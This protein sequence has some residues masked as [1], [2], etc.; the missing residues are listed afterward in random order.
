MYQSQGGINA[1]MYAVVQ[2]SYVMYRCIRYISIYTVYLCVLHSVSL[3]TNVLDYSALNEVIQ[4]K[5]D[6]TEMDR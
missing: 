4:M 2:N 1:Y 5:H 6:T 3:S